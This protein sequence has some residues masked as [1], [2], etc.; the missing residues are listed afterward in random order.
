MPVYK[1]HYFDARGRAEVTRMLFKL[2]EQAFE[3]IRLA[4]DDW[5]GPNQPR[6][7]RM[8]V[9]ILSCFCYKHVRFNELNLMPSEC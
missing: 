5:F 7:S 6:K 4:D 9:Y 2:G 3:D 8:T 1:L